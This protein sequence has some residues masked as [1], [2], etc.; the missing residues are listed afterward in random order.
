MGAAV[1]ILC[2]KCDLESALPVS[3]ISQVLAMEVSKG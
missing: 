3:Q 1:L 2:N